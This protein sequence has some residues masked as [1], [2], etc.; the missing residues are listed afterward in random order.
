MEPD[1]PLKAHGLLLKKSQA[2]C[3]A[4]VRKGKVSKP[5]IAIQAKL[6]LRKT[7]AAL[8]TLSQLGLVKQNQAM[9][10]HLTPRGRACRYRTV[11]DRLRRNSQV[12]GPG[13][14]RLLKLLDRPMRA[15]EVVEQLGVTHQ[16]VRQLVIKLHAQGYV[17]FGDAENPFWIIRRTDDRTPLL[18]RDEERLLSAIPQDYVTNVVKIRLAAR[19]PENAVRKILSRLIANL[20]VEEFDGLQGNKVYRLSDT[21]HNHPQ[22]D[23]SARRAT[24]P[25]LPVESDRIREVL[26]TISNAGALRIRDVTEVLGIPRKSINALMQYLKRK[27]LVKKTG[28]EFEAPY[29]LTSEGRAALAEMTRRRAA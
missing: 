10:W 22:R 1:M 17:T 13:G 2:A 29:S 26:S 14:R 4:A 5:E 21:G 25:R 18:S 6:D 16:R 27:L 28:S 15:T 11:P 23:H 19:M 7:S 3:L 24:V 8:G 12:P 20:F 9:R